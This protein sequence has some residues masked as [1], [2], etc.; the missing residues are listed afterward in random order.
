MTTHLSGILISG[1]KTLE[2]ATTLQERDSGKTFF[3]SADTEFAVTLPVPVKGMSFDFI[4]AQ[5]PSGAD[6]T[7]VCSSSTNLIHG[8]ITTSAD[9]TA[10]D[11]S[12]GTAQGAVTF[13]DGNALVGDRVH[14][15]CD[16]TYWYATGFCSAADGITLDVQAST[17][18]SLSP[19]ISP[20]ISAS[21]SPSISPSYSPSISPS[22]S[23]T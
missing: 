18:P 2:V 4:V 8:N 15:E 7:V 22:I 9:G 20:S 13:V 17:S 21:L 16:G 19:S 23:P 12:A 10:A 6:Y 3:L 5:A 11:T 1:S 14:L